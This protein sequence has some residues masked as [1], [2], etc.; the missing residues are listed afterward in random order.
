[1]MADGGTPADSSI[2]NS[3]SCRDCLIVTCCTRYVDV[4]LAICRKLNGREMQRLAL[5]CKALYNFICTQPYCDKLW[6][7]LCLSD[8]GI[9]PTVTATETNELAA[10]KRGGIGIR[11]GE[12]TGT[13]TGRGKAIVAFNSTPRVASIPFSSVST[14][15]QDVHMLADNRMVNIWVQNKCT[16]PDSEACKIVAQTLIEKWYATSETNVNKILCWYFSPAWISMLCFELETETDADCF[17][18]WID[19]DKGLLSSF[20]NE[21]WSVE[22]REKG[23]GTPYMLQRYGLVRQHIVDQN[24]FPIRCSESILQRSPFMWSKVYS[25]LSALSS[26][27]PEQHSLFVKCENRKPAAVNRKKAGLMEECRPGPCAS[28]LAVIGLS[29]SGKRTLVGK[30][31]QMFPYDPYTCSLYQEDNKDRHLSMVYLKESEHLFLTGIYN[32]DES[33]DPGYLELILS[34]ANAVIFVIDC[35]DIES[36]VPLLRETLKKLSSS[37]CRNIPLVVANNRFK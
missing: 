27:L 15:E 16:Y 21:N 18:K 17:Y 25:N 20:S 9:I 2:E 11:I 30:L 4:I 6:A 36:S 24:R 13:T 14:P 37:S 8:F 31:Q 12:G 22:L 23:C 10:E 33:R 29:G 34:Q 5:T 19:G 32:L 26:S 35:L 1:M 7:H 3:H 28:L